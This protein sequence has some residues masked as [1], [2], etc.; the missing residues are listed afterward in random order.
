MGGA[1]FFRSQSELNMFLISKLFCL[2]ER[3]GCN[4]CYEGFTSEQRAYVL[5]MARYMNFFA[6]HDQVIQI[7]IV[8]SVL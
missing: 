7:L 4:F 1:I 3:K 8:Q 5:I 6:I 2:L